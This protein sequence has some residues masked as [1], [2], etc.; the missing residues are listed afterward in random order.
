MPLLLT[1]DLF[2]KHD[3]G[4]GHP[5]RAERLREIRR[6]LEQDPIDGVVWRTPTPASRE[7]IVRVHDDAYVSTIEGTRGLYARFD[8]DTGASPDTVDAAF[9]AAGAGINAVHEV[10]SGEHKRVFCL[11]RPPGHHAERDRAM[12]FCIFDNVAVAAAEALQQPG[13]DRVLIVDWDVHHGNGTQHIFYERSDVLV[14]NTLQWPHYPG[15]GFLT[16]LGKGAGEGYNINVPFP[17]GCNDADYL[18]AFQEVLVPVA[19]QYKPNIVFISAGFDAHREDPLGG[20]RL[21]ENGFASLCTIV[22]DIAEKHADGRLV[23]FLE[24]G[25]DTSALARSVR[26]CVEVLVG[27]EVQFTTDKPQRGAALLGQV[28]RNVAKYWPAPK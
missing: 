13:I 18:A 17:S 12:G 23:M 10:I 7:S 25:Y 4:P 9:L 24:G 6:V 2:L 11:V 26:S 27:K 3:P 22:L 21:S 16:D 19:E 14:F 8:P 15:T 20:M 1:D 5:E 28:K